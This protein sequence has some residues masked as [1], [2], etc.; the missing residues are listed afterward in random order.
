MID[1][2]DNSLI[3]LKSNID[4]DRDLKLFSPKII[5]SNSERCL[6]FQMYHNINHDEENDGPFLVNVYER[7]TGKGN[8]EYL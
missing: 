2:I 6:E 5:S 3:T 7:I 8:F 4:E 1:E